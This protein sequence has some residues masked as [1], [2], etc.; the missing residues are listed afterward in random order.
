MVGGGFRQGLF[1]VAALSASIDAGR[2]L[3]VTDI[4]AA[5]EQRR[6][7]AARA[8]VAQ[9]QAA[10]QQYLERRGLR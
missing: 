8:H 6:I 9:S 4:L 10:T 5:Y 3:E 2:G 1:D 7:D